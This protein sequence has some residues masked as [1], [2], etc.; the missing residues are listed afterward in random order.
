MF[1]QS[2]TCVAS[3]IINAI[4]SARMIFVPINGLDIASF[5]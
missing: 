2:P 3:V 1:S 5:E 4:R